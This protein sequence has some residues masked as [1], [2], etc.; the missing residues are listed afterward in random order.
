M[1]TATD[2][3]TRRPPGTIEAV[4]LKWSL[5]P[6]REGG[7]TMP[8]LAVHYHP[9]IGWSLSVGDSTLA[10]ACP[11]FLSMCWRSWRRTRRLRR[12]V[13]I[14]AEREG[15]VVTYRV[16]QGLVDPAERRR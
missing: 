2:E 10:A 14:S 13:V 1:S 6:Q 8:L 9:A 7:R 3:A 5:G 11:S 15:D 4:Q 16:Q 12:A